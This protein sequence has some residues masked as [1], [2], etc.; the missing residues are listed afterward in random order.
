MKILFL[1]NFRWVQKFGALTSAPQRLKEVK[2]ADKI[3]ISAFI[4]Q[5]KQTRHT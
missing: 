3:P 1:F 4:H 2:G 5:N